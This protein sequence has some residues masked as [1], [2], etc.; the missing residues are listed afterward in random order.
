MG[1]I[2]TNQTAIVIMNPVNI[3]RFE[4]FVLTVICSPL[5]PLLL[6]WGIGSRLL[7]RETSAGFS[8]NSIKETGS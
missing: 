5:Y 8:Y 1:A 3:F 7:S 4:I 2:N 6:T